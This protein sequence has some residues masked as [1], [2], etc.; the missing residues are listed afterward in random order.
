MMRVLI[1][2]EAAE[3]LS[4][5]LRDVGATP[6]HLPLIELSATGARPPSSVPDAVLVTSAAVVRFVSDLAGTIGQARVV[7]VGPRTK[8]ALEASGVEVAVVG[9]QGGL[10]AVN[11]ASLKPGETAWYVGAE[12]P[13][14]DLCAALDQAGW[15]RW[16]VYRSNAPDGSTIGR[17]EPDAV[18]VVTFASG[19][20]VQAYVD[21][22]GTPVAPVAVIG[23]STASMAKS[24]GVSVNVVAR[25]PTMESLVAAVRTL[26]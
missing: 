24:L 11:L 25:T 7:A 10:D 14:I 26:F 1:T 22:F 8:D 19:S 4:T 5:L 16:P 9:S 12:Q 21:R 18:D 6:I 3:P 20:A 23:S 2:R 15:I 17:V 13:S